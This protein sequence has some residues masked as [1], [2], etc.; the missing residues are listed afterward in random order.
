M[1]EILAARRREGVA[2]R[3]DL[4]AEAKVGTRL[5]QQAQRPPSC[6][7][8]PAFSNVPSAPSAARLTRSVLAGLEADPAALAHGEEELREQRVCTQSTQAM[9]STTPRRTEAE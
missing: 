5:V 3:L 8:R 2:R 7:A 6:A 4:A 9:S 1:V